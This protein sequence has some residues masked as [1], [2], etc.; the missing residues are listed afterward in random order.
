MTENI[1]QIQEE[2]ATISAPYRPLLKEYRRTEGELAGFKKSPKTAVILRERKK[3]K[4]TLNQFEKAIS[5]CE[6]IVKDMQQLSEVMGKLDAHN[7]AVKRFN[8]RQTAA[9]QQG[10]IT[11]KKNSHLQK[12]EKRLK[13][14]A[15][16]FQRE[17]DSIN[18]HLL[19]L[20]YVNKYLRILAFLDPFWKRFSWL[21]R[22]IKSYFLDYKAV[23][24]TA[25]LDNLSWRLW[26]WVIKV[27]GTS[28]KLAICKEPV[29]RDLEEANAQ[30]HTARKTLWMEAKQVLLKLKE[31]REKEIQWACKD[32]NRL[33]HYLSYRSYGRQET[34]A[35]FAQANPGIDMEVIMAS[36]PVCQALSLAARRRRRHPPLESAIK[37]QVYSNL[38]WKFMLLDEQLKTVADLPVLSESETFLCAL[39]QGLAIIGSKAKPLRIIA[40]LGIITKKPLASLR[41]HKRISYADPKGWKIFRIGK[42]RIIMNITEKEKDIVEAGF[43]VRYRDDAYED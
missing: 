14:T 5:E 19:D 22:F 7:A 38:Q 18:G 30:Y 35:R 20:F 4:E 31:Q 8:V 40:Q 10:L 17:F 43:I 24:Q 2:W 32:T 42:F 11:W 6:E 33:W 37:E 15:R 36:R 12:E 27:K 3:I 28:Y 29:K 1:S 9:N 41:R 25:L 16:C 13:K 23:R 39:T 21:H 34:L 26:L